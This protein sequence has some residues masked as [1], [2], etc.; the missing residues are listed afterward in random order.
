MIRIVVIKVLD[1]IK[2][3]GMAQEILSSHSSVITTRLGFHELNDDVCSRQACIILH[4]NGSEEKIGDLMSDLNNL[5]GADVVEM[6]FE[7]EVNSS[8]RTV[9]GKDRILGVLTEKKPE[10]VKSV[11]KLLT[12]YGCVIRTRLGIN[13]IFF[14]RPVGLI[15]LELTG[16][17]NQMDLLEEDLVKIAGARVRKILT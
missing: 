2:E 4:L 7:H 12:S 10:A 14:G 6:D 16:D 17:A 11:Q 15:I 5:E 13:E 8:E 3:A 1:R 9:A